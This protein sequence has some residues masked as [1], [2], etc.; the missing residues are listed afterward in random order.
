MSLC[1]LG[2]LFCSKRIFMSDVTACF[3]SLSC[4]LF[5]MFVDMKTLVEIQLSDCRAEE[6]RTVSVVV[7]LFE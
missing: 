6:L 3:F 1:L 5:C 2:F 7:Q 4:M